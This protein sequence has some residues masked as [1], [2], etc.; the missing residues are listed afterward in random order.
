MTTEDIVNIIAFILK[1]NSNAPII[2]YE[3]LNSIFNS[4]N[5][6][7]LNKRLFSLKQT[8]NVA[9]N[10]Y[11]DSE[12]TRFIT[13]KDIV[14][15]DGI[16]N[17]PENYILGLGGVYLKGDEIKTFDCVD[18]Q[19]YYNMIRNISA[20]KIKN[21][22]VI[23]EKGNS[24]Y[25]YPNNYEYIEFMYL[26][27]PKSGRVIYSY[28]DNLGI[29]TISGYDNFEWTENVYPEIIRETLNYLGVQVSLD[30]IN[31]TIQN[32]N[33]KANEIVER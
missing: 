22:G 1:D 26:R 16:A 4:V 30:F 23:V 32:I 5:N 13:N 33:D 21:W 25:I 15:T 12:L 27:S 18:N 20:K 8:G 29:N 9:K 6:S 19:T 2:H 3:E 10:I 17:F 14:F 31:N 11:L 7:I 28:D 24:L